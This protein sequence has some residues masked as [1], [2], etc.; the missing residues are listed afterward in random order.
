MTVSVVVPV[1]NHA[2]WV[3]RCFAAIDAQD[4]DDV[5]V[6]AVDD[7]SA[8][9]SW[10]A[11]ASHR[12]TCTRRVRSLRAPH[13]GAHAAI[14]RG[15]AGASGDWVAVCNVDDVFAPHRV[16]TLVARA[17]TAG[18]RF[19]F[20]GV[21][22]IDERDGDV[23]DDVPFARDVR[24]RQR[25]IAGY[26]SVGFATLLSNVAVSTG[27]FFFER[28]LLNEVG[29]FRPYRYVHDWDFLLRVVLFTEP[30]FVP[31]P[32]YAYRLHATNTFRSLGTL[33]EV[34]CPQVL[35][36]YLRAAVSG[37]PPNRLAPSPRNW[38]GYFET[39]LMEHHWLRQYLYGWNDVDD[40]VYR[41]SEEAAEE[42][43]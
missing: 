30:L 15:L 41:P 28:A 22:V 16:S 24:R 5:E 4:H 25:E 40:V 1:Y 21:R 14:N 26:P 43:A 2:E 3:P 10:D 6:I 13:R 38:P 36:R 33:D 37:R 12:W 39:F 19:A 34:E 27:N 23:P 18:A 29:F 8:D 31:A 32:L 11:I 17:R 7:G 9:G 42:P 20:T 35:R